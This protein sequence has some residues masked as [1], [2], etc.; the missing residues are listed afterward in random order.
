MDEKFIVVFGLNLLLTPYIWKSF[1]KH[2][3]FVS[4]NC[5]NV[6]IVN[7]VHLWL[8]LQLISDTESRG[9]RRKILL[10]LQ[11]EDHNPSKKMK[12]AKDGGKKK[13][14]KKPKQ[15]DT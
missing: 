7:Q 1:I 3:K 9:L 11:V 10:Y 12:V 6:S 14:G 2:I 8:G 5:S 13:K 15:K 4:W